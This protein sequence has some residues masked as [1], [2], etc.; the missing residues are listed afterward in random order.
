MAQSLHPD[1]LR[2]YGIEVVEVPGWRTRKTSSLGFNP[3]GFICH[4]TA[5]RNS[6]NLIIRDKL[7][8]YYIPKSGEVHVVSVNRTAHP[9]WGDPA[10]RDRARQDLVPMPVAQVRARRDNSMRGYRHWVGVEVEN[11][12]DGRD[13]YTDVQLD[14]MIKLAAAHCLEFGWTVNRVIHHKE[15]TS[16][17]ID[18]SYNGDVRLRVAFQMLAYS[19]LG[20]GPGNGEDL[21]MPTIKDYYDGLNGVPGKPLPPGWAAEAVR[22]TIESNITSGSA[23]ASSPVDE[24]RFHVML[25]N[26]FTNASKAGPQGP[27][28]PQGPQGPPGPPGD[29]GDVEWPLTVTM[30]PL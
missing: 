30:E 14:S 3:I 28:G 7:S 19:K 21:F 5:G 25:H 16:R 17:K 13:P 26:F 1:V 20:Y 8:G 10:V 6:L 23:E 18:M 27:T 9:G 29:S 4:H 11:L 2:A 15:W 22:W 12:G 24:I